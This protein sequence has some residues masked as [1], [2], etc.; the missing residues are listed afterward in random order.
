VALLMRR[1]AETIPRIHLL[2]R[3]ICLWTGQAFKGN[4]CSADVATCDLAPPWDIVDVDL[5]TV[6]VPSALIPAP[7]P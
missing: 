7:A 1:Q 3:E 6:Q 4:E 5:A 2:D